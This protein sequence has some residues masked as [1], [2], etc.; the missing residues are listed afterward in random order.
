MIVLE[1]ARSGRIKN[2]DY[3]LGL[4]VDVVTFFP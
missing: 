1:V 3:Q 2:S 4:T